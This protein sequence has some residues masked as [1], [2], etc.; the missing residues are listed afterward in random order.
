MWSSLL[1]TGQHNKQADD[2]QKLTEET[3]DLHTESP[4]PTDKMEEEMVRLLSNEGSDT[5]ETTLQIH[6]ITLLNIRVM[7]YNTACN[8]K[9]KSLQLTV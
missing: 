7:S 3:T 8:I 9:K 1:P 6:H 5:A 4:Q 2:L